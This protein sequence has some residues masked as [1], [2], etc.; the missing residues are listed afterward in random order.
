[1][2]KSN[3]MLA[4]E[5]LARVWRQGQ[6]AAELMRAAFAPPVNIA[7]ISLVRLI[8]QG[9]SFLHKHHEDNFTCDNYNIRRD[10]DRL[11]LSTMWT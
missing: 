8:T 2:Q 6:P 1:L 4:H 11:F 5:M 7:G 9:R 3:A 10:R